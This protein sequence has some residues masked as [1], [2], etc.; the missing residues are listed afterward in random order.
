M[1]QYKSASHHSTKRERKTKPDRT[2]APTTP[3]I[4]YAQPLQV[5]AT[6]QP[7]NLSTFP[8]G[9]EHITQQSANF[10]ADPSTN[11][12][13]QEPER[14]TRRERIDK[15]Q[16]TRYA[17]VRHGVSIF[18]QVGVHSEQVRAGITN[19]EA[20]IPTD[21]GGKTPRMPS[22]VLPKPSCV[23]SYDGTQAQPQPAPRK[24]A[25]NFL[26]SAQIR[27]RRLN[28]SRS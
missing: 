3:T 8:P 21:R 27:E 15:A 12:W 17:A 5:H 23:H 2:I 22:E 18:H 14:S 26:I 25:T 11:V 24:K 7:A 6:P 28:L 20:T 10:N 13:G 16:H 1:Q 19:K 9:Q 4:P